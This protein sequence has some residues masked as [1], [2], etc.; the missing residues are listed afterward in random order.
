M[1]MRIRNDNPHLKKMKKNN[2]K[3]TRNQC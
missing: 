1:N 3:W 2:Q